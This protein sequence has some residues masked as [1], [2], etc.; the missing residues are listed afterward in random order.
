MVLSKKY[1]AKHG[2]LG[3]LPTVAALVIIWVTGGQPLTAT[4]LQRSQLQISH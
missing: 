2:K 1:V 3:K 4:Q